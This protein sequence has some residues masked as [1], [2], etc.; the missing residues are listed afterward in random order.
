MVWSIVDCAEK[1]AALLADLP[2]TSEPLPPPATSLRRTEVTVKR[3]EPSRPISTAWL[4]RS[5]TDRE[6][7]RERTLQT[8]PVQTIRV[9]PL[10]PAFFDSHWAS[11]VDEGRAAA[12]A[13]RRHRSVDGRPGR[14]ADL[15]ADEAERALGQAGR[16]LAVAARAGIVD[17]IVDDE[18]AAGTD[19]QGRLVVEHELHRAGIGGLD[20]L[21]RDDAGADL[22]RTGAAARRRSGRCRLDRRG[23]ADGVAEGGAGN[24]TK[25]AAA[26][27]T[28]AIRVAT[29]PAMAMRS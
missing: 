9:Q 20:A 8:P 26:S 18:V 12:H 27:A 16:E 22:E 3:T 24:A 19:R 21:A 5:W 23:G 10:S 7:T 6:S 29:A 11:W 13:E 14:M 17:E 25:A 2:I 1:R 15:A 28:H 4:T